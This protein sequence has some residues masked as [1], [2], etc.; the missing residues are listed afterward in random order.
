MHFITEE[1]HHPEPHVYAP[2]ALPYK[3]SP[4]YKPYKPVYKPSGSP[5]VPVYQPRGSPVPAYKPSS[6]GPIPVYKPKIHYKS[7]IKPAKATEKPSDD[8]VAAKAAEPLDNNNAIPAAVKAVLKEAVAAKE[9]QAADNYAATTSA[10][11]YRSLPPRQQIGYGSSP[12]ARKYSVG[13]IHHHK[14]KLVY[15]PTAKPH[16]LPRKPAAAAYHAGTATPVY[17]STPKPVYHSTPA[18]VYHSTPAPV[19]HSTPKPV[20]HSTLAPVYHSTP[21]PVYH[22]TPAPVYPLGGHN[23]YR[24]KIAVKP[25]SPA[26]K[27]DTIVPKLVHY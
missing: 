17:H 1:K 3:A 26:L 11:A 22:S 27:L 4:V 23:V 9:Q 7:L 21:A 20:Y 12:K 18:P 10:S 19:Y 13:P 8:D 6:G 15:G 5:A 25:K 16:S 2:K 24:S 14:S